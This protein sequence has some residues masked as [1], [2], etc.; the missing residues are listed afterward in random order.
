MMFFTLIFY[1]KKDAEDTA[2]AALGVLF[3]ETVLLQPRF[4]EA[5][6]SPL[7]WSGPW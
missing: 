7:T 1:L 6:E 3:S 2:F 5:Y 4:F